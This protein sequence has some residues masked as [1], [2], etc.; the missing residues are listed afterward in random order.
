MRRLTTFLAV[1]A[2]VLGAVGTASAVTPGQANPVKIDIMGMYAHPDDEA[3][4]IAPCGVMKDLFDQ[5]CGVI[6]L[7][8]G[9]GG[10]N[11][12]GT[13][14]GPALGIRREAEERV[15]QGHTGTTNIFYVEAPDFYYN[16]SAPLTEYFWGHDKS[17]SRVVR[18]I[19]ETRPDILMA[20]SPT[21]GH[22]NHQET[23]RLAWEAFYAAADPSMFPEQLTGPN[24]LN[25]W[26]IKKL[27]SGG[28]TAGTGVP[29]QSAS[30][31]TMPDCNTGFVPAATNLDNVVGVWTGY[32]SS[33]MYLPG[34]PQGKPAGT[35]KTYAQLGSEGSAS[36]PTQGRN[37]YTGTANNGCTRYAV[38]QS[39]VPFQLNS[40][41][42]E[43]LLY[44]ATLPDPGG[45]P[46]GTMYYLTYDRFFN[47][48]GQPFEV[49]VHAKAAPGHE[50]E[51]LSVALALPAGWTASGSGT[52]P[53]LGY[54]KESS[55]T[56]TVTPSATAVFGRYRIAAT[57]TWGSL[58]A[59]TN[60]VVSI[61]PAVEG[62]AQ[63][64]AAYLDLDGWLGRTGFYR[65]NRSAAVL[66][67]GAGETISVPVNV[68]N[69]TAS[70]Q[71]GD[72]TLAMPAGFAVDAA[73]KSY[74][75]LAG[76]ADTTLVFE[77]TNTNPALPTASTHSVSV[78]TTSGAG[79]SGETLSLNFV[80][81]TTIPHAVAAP[82]LDGI[83]GA[84]EYTGASLDLSKRW[85]GS[86]CSPDG[87]DCGAGTYGKVTW[88]DDALYVFVHV[89]DD[90]AGTPVTPADC[91][92]HWR[93]DSVEILLDPRGNSE[94]TSTTFKAGIFPW[95]TT[96]A[97]CWERDADNYQGYGAVTAPGMDVVANVTPIDPVTHAYAGYDLE[98][99]IDLADL[100]AAI[101]PT[102]NPVTDVDP[103]HLGFNITPYDSDTQNLQGQTRLAWS[104]YGGVQGDPYRWGHAYLDGYVPP[105]GRPTTPID[106]IIDATAALSV[107]SPQSIYQSVHD[108][109]PMAGLPA[110]PA[111]AKLD[112]KSVRLEAAALAITY[113][114]NG[115]GRAHLFAWAGDQ[116]V[117]IWGSAVTPPEPPYPPD[118]SG[119]LMGDLVVNVSSTMT[120]TAS[121]PLTASQRAKLAAD[122]TLLI[123]WAADVNGGVQAMEVPIVP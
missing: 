83:A 54:G 77:V 84:G 90:L 20:H 69:W 95:T 18:I 55:A 25:T 106:P 120:Q 56:F 13:E 8:R 26:Q 62:R 34:N 73:T 99:K 51:D 97:P 16:T 10:G 114:A 112:I 11:A 65:V 70:A 88:Y 67:I 41:V 15:A 110:A 1:A 45:F 108:G 82:T 64:I 35:F 49:T 23:G 33:V 17:L 22:G 50:Y 89:V 58:S 30:P 111:N 40:Q 4:M 43:G 105:A 44:G 85:E 100:P 12:V 80:P 94:N 96:G 72:V 38:V 7:T 104:N 122:G 48:A 91:V 123:S 32:E 117:A 53:F 52:I 66:P 21:G 14:T 98:V 107:D 119:H 28:S 29:G 63:R 87:T 3:G 6:M 101:G 109:V 71:S 121:I 118:M 31:F 68:H 36:Y 74:A 76:G 57:T 2:L 93:T 116:H 37:F 81:G 75:G 24:A 47:V 115:P 39:R 5:R 60:E 59:Y 27:I 61:V 79:S 86:N 102:G 113:K 9:E 92:A 103:V 46:L 42:D 78:T 19:R